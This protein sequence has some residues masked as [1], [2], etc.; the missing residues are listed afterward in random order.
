MSEGEKLVKA[1]M[2]D[3]RIS[4]CILARNRCKQKSLM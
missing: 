2:V 3:A 1:A 4:G